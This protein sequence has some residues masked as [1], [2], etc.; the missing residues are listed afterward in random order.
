HFYCDPTSARK[1]LQSGANIT[2]IPLDVTR[3][4]VFSPSDLLELPVPESN[5]SQFLRKIVPFGIR[6]SSNLYGIEGFHMKDVLAIVALTLRKALT[7]HPYFVDVET[8]GELTRG[9]SVVD[10][11]PN[12]AGKPNVDLAVGVDVLAVRDYIFETL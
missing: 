12:P 6:A 8:Q 4:L 9:V 3:K 2:L 5:T 7:V 1:V 11:R 10:A